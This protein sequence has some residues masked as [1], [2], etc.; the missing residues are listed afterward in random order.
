MKVVSHKTEGLIEKFV[1]DI[2]GYKY[3]F[4]EFLDKNCLSIGSELLDGHG[5][6]VVDKAVIGVIQKL[7]DRYLADEFS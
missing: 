1:V 3:Y 4:T 5:R 6:E 7:I 2:E